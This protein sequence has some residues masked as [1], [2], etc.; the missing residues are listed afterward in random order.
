M[1]EYGNFRFNL[2][3]GEDEKY[4]KITA[5]GIRN[6]TAGFSQY[7]LKEGLQTLLR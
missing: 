2:G 5:V 4:H 6:V 1:T 3:P 7:G